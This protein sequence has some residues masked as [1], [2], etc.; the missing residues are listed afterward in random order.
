MP[1]A[2]PNS[3]V[4]YGPIRFGDTDYRYT[5]S[6]FAIGDRRIVTTSHSCLDDNPT[7]LTFPAF[8]STRSHPGRVVSRVGD[9]TVIDLDAP[10]GSP[11]L[12]LADQGPSLGERVTIL[13]GSGASH[14]AVAATVVGADSIRVDRWYEPLR[15]GSSGSPVVNA[16]GEVVGMVFA[17]LTIGNRTLIS[18]HTVEEIRR[19][20]A[21]L[22]ADAPSVSTAGTPRATAAR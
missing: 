22:G 14:A 18:I 10:F 7:L 9:I 11:S 12:R 4:S 15:K 6:G 3:V 13:D 2:G 16:A 21:T 5:G 17:N 8:L 1:G 19:A 20:L